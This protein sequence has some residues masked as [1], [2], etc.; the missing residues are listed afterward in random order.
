MDNEKI[1]FSIIMPAYG[2]EKTIRKSIEDIL[3]QTYLEWELI[4]VDDASKDLSGEIAEGFAAN[5]SRIKVVHHKQN[6]GVAEARNTGIE[7]ATGDYILFFDAGD[8]VEKNALE[9]IYTKLYDHQSDVVVL[10]CLEEYYSSDGKLKYAV[11]HSL[12]TEYSEDVDTIHRRV[13]ELNKETLYGYP[14]NKA[15]KASIIKEHDIRFENYPFGEDILFNMEFFNYV[16]SMYILSDE[17]YHYYNY[18]DD[19]HRLTTKY[20]PEYFEYQK[21]RING[22]YSQQENWGT[23]D[24]KIK[25]SLSAEYFRSFLSMMEREYEHGTK[26]SEILERAHHETKEGLYNSLNR[27]V[28]QNS[29]IFQFLYQPLA[30]GDFHRAFRRMRL[31]SFVRKHF[32]GVF[33]KLKQIR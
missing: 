21:K 17:L 6:K 16:E 33:A 19:N 1:K 25:E 26:K 28:P 23:L 9:L 2:V 24:E 29:R 20:L 13:M 22:L 8:S 15:Y 31:V 12:V 7:K 27:Y 14:W 18:L 30:E 10:G 4:V 3:Q 5:N 11:S 32:K